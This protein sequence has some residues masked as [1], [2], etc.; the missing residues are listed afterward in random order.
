MKIP[1]IVVA[2]PT[3][4][5]KSALALELALKYGGEIVSADSMQVYKGLNIGTAKPTDEERKAVKHHLVD[6]LE[7]NEGFSAAEFCKRAREAVSDIHSRGSLPIIVGGTGLYID[8]LLYGLSYSHS[9]ENSPLREE[10]SLT[11]EKEGASAVHDI[12]RELDSEA[13][14]SIHPNNLKR[15]IRAIE[16]IKATGKSLAESV[17]KPRL[18]G[19]YDFLYTVISPERKTLY[20]RIDSRVDNMMERGLYDEALWLFSTDTDRAAACMQAIGYKEFLPVYE[21]KMP[22]SVAVDVLKRDTRHYAKRQLTWF[23]RHSEAV[24]ISSA[25]LKELENTEQFKAFFKKL[26]GVKET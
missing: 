17:D 10:L 13:A 3:A 26:G 19:E 14:D 4:S 12:L 16:I 8:S 15:V 11:A 22:I 6:I 7:L 24:Y 18:E 20:D 2:G 9:N 25:S 5:G 23:K 1:V 21:G